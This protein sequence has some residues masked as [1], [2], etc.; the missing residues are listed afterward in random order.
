M[1]NST[2][3]SCVLFI[4]CSPRVISWI[5]IIQ[6]YNQGP[7][8]DRIYSF[9]S[10]LAVLCL[11]ISFCFFFCHLVMSDFC[12]PWTAAWLLCPSP[13][14]RV[15]QVHIHCVSDAIQ[16]THAFAVLCL[17]TQSCPTL[18]DPMDCNP[19][20]SSVHGDSLGKNTRVSCHALL[21]AIFPTQE[22]NP[23]L[24]HCRQILYHVS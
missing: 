22:S 8:I 2:E 4:L 9:Y 5:T 18:C 16:P 21:Q 10:D 23:G 14:P 7:D 19:P 20:G 24:S 1:R 13:S 12:A 6:Y 11:C 3:R 17:V 15:S